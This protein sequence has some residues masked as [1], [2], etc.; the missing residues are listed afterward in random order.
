MTEQQPRPGDRVRVTYEATFNRTDAEGTVVLHP[1]DELPR[2]R[3]ARLPRGA[4]VEVLPPPTLAQR[5]AALADEMEQ[6][7]HPVLAGTFDIRESFARRIREELAATEPQH[8]TLM[9]GMQG[10]FGPFNPIIPRTLPSGHD[11]PHNWADPI[12]SDR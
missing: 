11:G 8:R 5:M 9:C 2:L 1:G 12:G 6:A 10:S 4:T 7:A 3:M